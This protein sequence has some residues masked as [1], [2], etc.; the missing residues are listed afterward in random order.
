LALLRSI[1]TLYKKW[2]ILIIFSSFKIPTL[3]SL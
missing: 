3:C 2:W 1:T